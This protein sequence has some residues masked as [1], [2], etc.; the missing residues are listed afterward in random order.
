MNVGVLY[1]EG[2][3]NHEIVFACHEFRKHNLIAIGV[4][5]SAP[6]STE[7]QRI[8][9]D[10][11]IAD[12]DPQELDV[13]IIPG[14]FTHLLY[15]NRTA[16]DFIRAAAEGEALVGGICGAPYLMAKAGILKQR[17]CT[18][19]FIRFDPEA[20][21]YQFFGDAQ[22]VDADVV[23]DGN[24]VTA[25]GKAFIEFGLQMAKTAG[26]FEDQNAYDEEYSWLKN[27]V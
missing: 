14:G 23:V 1:Y 27:L 10:T 7:K 26:I 2:F 4:D 5:G 9:T 20:P 15:E 3:A 18:G 17:R 22:V 11:L 12:T 25:R 16:C 13:L 24:I 19:G 21:D 8:Q 6:V